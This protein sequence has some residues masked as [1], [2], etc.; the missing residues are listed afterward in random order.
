MDRPGIIDTPDIVDDLDMFGADSFPNEVVLIEYGNGQHAAF[1]HY[2]ANEHT[3]GVAA[4]SS[5]GRA[6]IFNERV[7]NCPPGST[8][9]SMKL[10]EALEIAA[11]KPPVIMCLMLCDDWENPKARFVR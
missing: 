7:G 10:E 3:H 6:V 4:F 1:A 8:Y 11:S 5:E 9:K 2:F